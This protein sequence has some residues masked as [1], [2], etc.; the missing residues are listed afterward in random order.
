M[1]IQESRQSTKN[2]SPSSK[3]ELIDN[4]TEKPSFKPAPIQNEKY[5]LGEDNESVSKMQSKPQITST[6]SKPFSIR[7]SPKKSNTNVSAPSNPLKQSMKSPKNNSP[8]RT[9]GQFKFENERQSYNQTKVRRPD[10]E[11]NE[12]RILSNTQLLDN[13]RGSIEADATENSRKSMNNLHMPNNKRIKGRLDSEKK[14]SHY[15]KNLSTNESSKPPMN[16]SSSQSSLGNLKG[17]MDLG[18][19]KKAYTQSSMTTQKEK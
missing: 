12:P 1:Q 2:S 15:S 7:E 4:R 19:K 9:K 17:A 5:S 18:N 13:R 11:E 6:K 14:E 16:N 8:K 10:F 3:G